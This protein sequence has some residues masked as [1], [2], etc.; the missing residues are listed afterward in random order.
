MKLHKTAFQVAM[1]GSLTLA[2]PQP[3]PRISTWKRQVQIQH[4]SRPDPDGL[5][6]ITGE[7]S[8]AS[9]VQAD[10]Q[11]LSLSIIRYRRWGEWTGKKRA[12]QVPSSYAGR[13]RVSG[14]RLP[15]RKLLEL[16]QGG[17]EIGEG[18]SGCEKHPCTC[19]GALNNPVVL[20][21]PGF[22]W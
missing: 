4:H 1:S 10:S 5:S 13:A 19:P 9:R 11:G 7:S 8:S 22:S 2:D 6:A 12:R 16:L 20:G 14:G 18:T 15:L 21:S 3:Q 17:Q